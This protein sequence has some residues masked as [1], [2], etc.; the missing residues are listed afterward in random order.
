MTAISSVLS[1]AFVQQIYIAQQS[2]TGASGPA[3]DTTTAGQDFEGNVIFIAQFGAVSGTVTT[4]QI[5][6]SDASGS[7]FVAVPIQGA[8]NALANWA[9]PTLPIVSN[10]TVY[11]SG[12]NASEL[13]RYVRFTIA[14]GTSAIVGVSMVAFKKTR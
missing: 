13:K 10:V 5:E 1:Q 11:L 4:L 7:G 2:G 9:G 6:H 14:T 12:I 8:V 3:F